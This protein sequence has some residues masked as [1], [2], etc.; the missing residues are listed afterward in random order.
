[1]CFKDFEE[2]SHMVYDVHTST[3]PWPSSVHMHAWPLPSFKVLVFYAKPVVYLKLNSV[4][5][6][7][8]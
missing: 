4:P 1:M 8:L 2:T 7:V 6:Q 5:E 3:N